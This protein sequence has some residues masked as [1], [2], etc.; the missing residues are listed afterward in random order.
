MNYKIN[1]ETGVEDSGLDSRLDQIQKAKYVKQE[2]NQDLKTKSRYKSVKK[3]HQ[4][5]KDKMG[6]RSGG[7]SSKNQS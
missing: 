1:S 6:I 4:E 3:K 2:P 7:R 5:S